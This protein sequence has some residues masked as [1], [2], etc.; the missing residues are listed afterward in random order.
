MQKKIYIWRD[1]AYKI[2]ISNKEGGYIKSMLVSNL[3]SGSLFI[4]SWYHIV[5]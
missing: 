4:S 5:S 3:D 2:E 1:L